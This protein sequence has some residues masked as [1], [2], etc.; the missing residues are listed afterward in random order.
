MLVCRVGFKQNIGH[1]GKE[2]VVCGALGHNRAMKMEWPAA[3]TAFWDRLAQYV[4]YFGIKFL[5]GDFNM[6]FT[7]VP[8]QLR[9]RGILCDCVAWYP[10][11][12]NKG[13]CGMETAVVGLSEQRL[14]FDSCGIFYIGGRVEIT[15]PWGC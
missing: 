14:G 6:S 9:S 15:R 5:A 8:K 1:L 7:E 3:W 11:Q 4:Q 10:W 13:P 12:R 2:F